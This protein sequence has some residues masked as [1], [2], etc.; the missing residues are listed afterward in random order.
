VWTWLNANTGAVQATAAVVTAVLTAVLIGITARYV[1]LTRKMLEANEASAR[2]SFMPDIEAN[3]E[4]THPRKNELAINIKNAADPPICILRARLIGG[5][6][7]KWTDTPGKGPEFVTEVKFGP[8]D[9]K[10]LNAVF[11]RKDEGASGAFNIRPVKQMEDEE[12]LKFL[13]YRISLSATVVAEVSD[14]TGRILYSF[15][16]RRDAQS[17]GKTKI[18]TRCPSVFDSELP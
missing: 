3:I 8:T 16:I 18:Q 6:V 5:S 7:F 9:I 17:G 1:V 13:D 14:I 11:L 10:T 4:F 2:V 15:A 12:W